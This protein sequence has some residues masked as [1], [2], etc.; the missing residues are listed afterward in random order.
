MADK[1]LLRS[2]VT[3]SDILPSNGTTRSREWFSKG[4]SLQRPVAM[5]YQCFLDWCNGS[6]HLWMVVER[7]AP[8]FYSGPRE[9]ATC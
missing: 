3:A 7:P 6:N 4:V 1:S 5:P 9:Q 8:R 2:L